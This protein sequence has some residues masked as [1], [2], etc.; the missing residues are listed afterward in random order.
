MAGMDKGNAYELLMEVAEVLGKLTNTD[1]A[2]E[3]PDA[4]DNFDEVIKKQYDKGNL[5]DEQF[6]DLAVTAF[7]DYFELKGEEND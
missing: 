3:H 6:N 5:T 2:E 4:W 1:W 7:Y